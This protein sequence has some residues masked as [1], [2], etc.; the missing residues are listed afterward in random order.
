MAAGRVSAWGSIHGGAMVPVAGWARGSRKCPLPLGHGQHHR[1]NASLRRRSSSRSVPWRSLANPGRASSAARASIR[2]P[3]VRSPSKRRPLSTHGSVTVAAYVSTTARMARLRSWSSETVRVAFASG[4][5][6]TGKTTL[7]T[8]FAALLAGREMAVQLLDA[9]VE[10]PDC[11]L[12]LQSD[13]RAQRTRRRP[14]PRGRR[15]ALHRLRR[16]RR[17][18]RL[19]GD[20]RHRDDRARLPRALPLVRG[21]HPALSRRCDP[22]GGSRDGTSG[23]RH[24]GAR[25]TSPGSRL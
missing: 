24:R 14:H 6:G 10:E 9:D 25:G 1:P 18:L 3:E 22:R 4:K 11:H 20:H 19:Q 13:G 17:G 15:R 5:G 2:A 12:F 7:A 16:V 21:L 8:N 23:T